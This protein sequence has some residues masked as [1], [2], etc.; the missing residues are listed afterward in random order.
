[1]ITLESPVINP[2]ELNIPK[3]G[4]QVS[5][6]FPNKTHVLRVRELKNQQSLSHGLK[7]EESNLKNQC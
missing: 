5:F 6:N 3:M 2:F 4:Q 7:L 1:M